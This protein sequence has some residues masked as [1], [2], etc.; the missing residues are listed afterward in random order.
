MKHSARFGGCRGKVFA[1]FALAGLRG[2]AEV[3]A[4]NYYF[5]D[6]QLAE[7]SR[8]WGKCLADSVQ[9]TAVDHVL[10]ARFQCYVAGV[11]DGQYGDVRKDK[12]LQ[13]FCESVADYLGD[14][15]E[16]WREPAAVLILRGIG[17]ESPPQK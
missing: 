13:Q 12:E 6:K 17:Q 5:D 2:V 8:A 14:H 15:P 4:G 10:A 7:W 3:T 9:K 1:L 11:V 16:A